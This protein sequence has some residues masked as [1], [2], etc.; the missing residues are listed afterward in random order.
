MLTSFLRVSGLLGGVISRSLIA[1][2]VAALGLA[3]APHPAGAAVPAAPIAT[4]VVDVTTTLGYESA[5]AAGTGIVLTRTGEVLTN[6]HVIR[7]ETDLRVIDPSTGKSYPATVVGY[8]V[9]RDVAVLQVTGAT[10]LH[11][12][13]I[14]NSANAKVGQKVTAV[15]NAQ[16]RGGAPAA[17]KGKI[18]RLRAS[19]TAQ[20]SAGIPEQLTGLIRID[21]ALQPGDSGGPLLN[22]AGRVIGMNTAA[23]TSLGS[24]EGFAIPINAALALAKQITAGLASTVVHIGTT[25]F[26]G[27]G[28]SA[29]SDPAT[30]GAVVLAIVPGS[31]AE[32]LGL[33][34]GDTITSIDG[35]P[36]SNF[37][38]VSSLLLQHTAGDTIALAWID[39]SGAAQTANVQ[40]AAGPPQ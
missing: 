4:G 14:G 27:V 33:V 6:N 31:P 40:T 9:A 23:N 11:P 7:G 20:D 22:A 18:T 36:V 39:A 34:E 17:A 10:N 37:G 2:T 19:I 1:A 12:V 28:V 26:L 5:S 30:G 15:G 38:S 16:G 35:Q 13:S 3:F 24:R 25:A 8:S 32:Q 21:A 29:T